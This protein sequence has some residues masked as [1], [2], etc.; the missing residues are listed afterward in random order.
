MNLIWISRIDNKVDTIMLDSKL[1]S[2]KWVIWN[3]YVNFVQNLATINSVN[4]PYL[5][6][7]VSVV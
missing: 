4:K 2:S 1:I 3:I 5:P 6:Q 7:E